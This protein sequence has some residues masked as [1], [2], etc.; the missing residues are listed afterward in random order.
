MTDK[1]M[2]SGE[3][4]AYESGK[5]SALKEQRAKS[6]DIIKLQVD[7]EHME[8]DLD[9]ANQTVDAL[10]A[11]LEGYCEKCLVRKIVYGVVSVIGLAVITALITL[12]VRRA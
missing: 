8:K 6:E 11:K 5:A 2:S 4:K 3:M 9:K 1:L 10:K 7:F 12:V